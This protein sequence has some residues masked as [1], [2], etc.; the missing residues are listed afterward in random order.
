MKEFKPVDFYDEQTN[1]FF[2]KVNPKG[3]SDERFFSMVDHWETEPIKRYLLSHTNHRLGTALRANAFWGDDLYSV[4][5]NRL[6]V[7]G[8]ALINPN[9][10]IAGTI[11][12]MQYFLEYKDKQDESGFLTLKSAIKL[13]EKNQRGLYI[14]TFV[15]NPEQTHNG[16]GTN[17]L[18][19]IVNN[20]TLLN[21]NAQPF[22][23]M[24]MVREDNNF[25]K[26]AF[27]NAD[28]KTLP[29]FS[30]NYLKFYYMH[31]R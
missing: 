25:S 12:L 30:E 5:N 24:G 22:C 18:R 19:T 26:G 11:D 23:T 27:K 8:T 28:F 7:I 29:I 13:L 14:R 9:T 21:N 6:E 3:E 16:Y 15:V 17:M 2:H 4:L 1:L 20:N 10:T 31:E